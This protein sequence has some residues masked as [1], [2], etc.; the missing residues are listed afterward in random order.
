MVLC[1]PIPDAF[2]HVWAISRDRSGGPGRAASLLCPPPRV[3]GPGREDGPLGGVPPRDGG[4]GIEGS[5][6]A[7]L[8]ASGIPNGEQEPNA[9]SLLLGARRVAGPVGQ[10]VGVPEGAEA[11]GLAEVGEGS[12]EEGQG[13]VVVLRSHVASFLGSLACSRDSPLIRHGAH[14]TAMGPSAFRLG[15]GLAF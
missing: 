6:R 3:G 15:V 2:S 14:C 13:A 4:H 8:E 9:V 1:R 11:V 12:A 7:V 10:R 5:E